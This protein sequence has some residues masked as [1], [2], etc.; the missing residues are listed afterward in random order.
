MVSG[1]II[2][3]GIQ[4]NQEKIRGQDFYV[5]NIWD[6]ERNEYL[7]QQER[8]KIVNTLGLKHV[9]IL[10]DS[11]TLRD[12]N[13]KTIDDIL[14]AADGPSLNASQREGLVFKSVDGSYM[15][16]AISNSWL[17]KNE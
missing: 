3:E 10:H 7:P 15:F 1:E 4:K 6:V 13:L 2:G 11:I 9:P 16:K 17:I 8:M 5:F 14:K 12:F